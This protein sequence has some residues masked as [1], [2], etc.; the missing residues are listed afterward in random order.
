MPAGSSPFAGS[1]RISRSGL[2]SS[3]WRDP[4]PLPHAERI[5]RDLV[6]QPLLERRRAAR[7]PGS[8]PP[9]RPGASARSG[10]GSRGRSGTCRGRATRRCS[11]RATSPRESRARG[12]GRGSGSRRRPA[13]RAR[14]ASGSSSSCRRRSARETRTPRR[15]RPRRRRPRRRRALPKRLVRWLRGEDDLGHGGDS[16]TGRDCEFSA[17]SPDSDSSPA[18]SCYSVRDAAL[19]P[20]L[21]LARPR[22][23]RR[24]GDASLRGRLLRSRCGAALGEPIGA[25]PPPPRAP[26]RREALGASGSCSCSATRSRG[27]R[28]T[29]R[30]GGS[31]PTSSTREEARPGRDREP[32]RQRRRV[33]RRSRSSS[34]SA[35]VRSLAAS[36]DV[37][38]LSIGGN[39]LSHAVPRGPDPAAG[40][41]AVEDVAAARAGYAQNL[42][43]GS[44]RCGRPTRR[45]RSSCSAS[46]IRSAT[47]GR[48]AASAR[49]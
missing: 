23:R 9:R 22:A 12:R 29:R 8:A 44:P 32:L 10:A 14:R 15:R 36:A 43:V 49:P 30:G 40:V 45:R 38:L 46:T 24:R 27:A 16:L 5:G 37:I 34:A 2:P 6:V 1:S 17:V 33:A 31:P 18:R 4:E 11:R 19:L 3:A 26:P 41:R 28:A 39:D 48:R 13:A 21:A 25:P 20:L 7:A 47:R 35:N 42:R